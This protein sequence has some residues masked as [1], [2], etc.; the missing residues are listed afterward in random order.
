L[1]IISTAGRFAG[2]QT[3]CHKTV[4]PRWHWAILQR[5]VPGSRTG[6][7]T[8]MRSNRPTPD[9][10]ILRRVMLLPLLVACIAGCSALL[11]SGRSRTELPWATYADAVKA[12]DRI[13]P[14]ETTRT[15]L[16]TE[17]IDPASN[18]SITILSYTD[19]LQ[20]LPALNAVPA[21]HLERGIADCLS[22]GKRCT[23]YSIAVRQVD[24]KRVGSFWSDALN[25]HRE[26]V[27]TGWSLNA[28]IVFV[29]DTVVYALA[30]GQP[31]IDQQD[32]TN[33]PLGPLQGLGESLRPRVP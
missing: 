3:A 7:P 4:V 33:N 15:G 29:D 22:A 21:E 11:P 2:G 19:L 26:S 12:I 25:F 23:A 31:K 14:Y 28:L 10:P 9:K 30:A 24:T 6:R 5:E 16:V 32:V 27:T 20:R 18:P 1:D 13:V 8:S 17:R